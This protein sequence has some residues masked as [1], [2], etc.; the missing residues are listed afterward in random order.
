MATMSKEEHNNYVVHV[1]HWIWQFVSHCFIITQHILK[2]LHKKDHQ[3][4]DASHKYI[5][6]SMPINSM[7]SMPNGS[8]LKCQ[9][10]KVRKVVLVRAYNLWI[11]YPNDNIIVHANDIQSCF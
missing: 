7:T 5:W 9:F 10:G 4:F 6:D 11:L 2:K 8:K 1:E 3:I